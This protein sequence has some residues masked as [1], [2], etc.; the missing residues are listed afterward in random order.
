MLTTERAICNSQ[1]SIHECGLL[2]TK[3]MISCILV[4]FEY[5]SI[6]D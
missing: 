2:D 4:S 1:S 5:L 6:T 3:L